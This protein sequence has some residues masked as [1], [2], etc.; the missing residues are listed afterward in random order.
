MAAHIVV[1]RDAE[2]GNSDGSNGQSA[3]SFWFRKIPDISMLGRRSN[4]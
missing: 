4:F 3:W 1:N 2:A